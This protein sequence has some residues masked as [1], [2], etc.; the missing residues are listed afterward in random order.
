MVT[1]IK[2][3]PNPA[4]LSGLHEYFAAGFFEEPDAAPV[5]RWSR[6]VRRRFE[7]REPVPYNGGRLYPAGPQLET[8]NKIVGPNYS[9][10]WGFNKLKLEELLES[11]TEAERQT[12]KEL[13]VTMAKMAKDRNVITLVEHALGGGGFTHSIP[14]YGRVIREGLNS[15]KERI[16]RG[17]KRAEQN[18]NKTK[19]DFY[20]GMLDVVAGIKCWHENI[21]SM[22]KQTA[23]TNGSTDLSQ[24]INALETVPFNPALSFYEAFV[25]YNFIFYLDDCDNPGRIDLELTS[26]YERDIHAKRISRE[27]VRTLVRAMWE[28]CNDNSGWSTAV[29]GTDAEGNSAYSDFTT[30]CLEAAQNMRRPNLQLHV[31]RDMPQEIWDAALDTISTGCGLPAFH[32]EEEFL[33]SLR[34][35]DLSIREEDLG[36]YNGG[37]CTET[38]IH[39]CSNVGSLDAGLNLPLILANTLRGNGN[40]N[41]GGNGAGGNGS[42]DSSGGNGGDTVGSFENFEHLLVRF[43][44]DISH[45]I[46]IITDQISQYQIVK[47]EANPQPMRSLL[48]DDCIDSGIEYNAGGARYN[49]SVINVA[50]IAD[51]ADSLSA[52]K[53]VVF[54]NGE[55]ASTELIEILKADFNG[56]ENLRR[57]LERCPRFGNDSP[58]VD[59]I[60]SDI[61]EHVFRELLKRK[62]WRGGRFLGSCLMFVTYAQAGV[63]VGASPDGR[64]AGDPIADSAGPHQGRDTEGPTAM[65][66]SVASIPHYLAPGTLVVNMRLSRRSFST[67][68]E[69]DKI[70]D[71]IRGYFD[72]GG[73]QLQISVVDQKVLLD[74][75]EN[76]ENYESLIVRIGGYSEYFNR[77]SPEL[78]RTVLERTEHAF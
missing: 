31:R 51:V 64:R 32:N 45:I 29:G 20:T 49:W 34:E 66:K 38:M 43:K 55:A 53:E 14:N 40:W 15:Y 71:L 77:L 22:L 37:G 50:G 9:Y 76:P 1:A 12:L 33:R 5:R 47:A 54:E 18:G 13:E 48:I 7:N 8:G 42:S 65:L 72:L 23:R 61:S 63:D 44:K 17:L 35:A 41:H 10:T 25:A 59:R 58:S 6:A 16:E 75:I 2:Q 52:F 4:V 24:L 30:V 69:R 70:R 19:I 73:M 62:P 28:N 78:K 39:G 60:A 57:R 11:G 21:L 56:N 27:E 46:D 74:A 36:L 67:G 68:A 3:H 26:F